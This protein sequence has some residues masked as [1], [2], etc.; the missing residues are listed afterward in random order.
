MDVVCPSMHASNW[1]A[2]TGF[3]NIAVESISNI[4]LNAEEKDI[5]YVV[6]VGDGIAKISGLFTIKAGELIVFSSGLRGLVLNLERDTVGAVILGDDSLVSEND[7]VSPLGQMFQI[8][9]GLDL[10]RHVV[11]ALGLSLEG[12]LSSDSIEPKLVEV[13]APGIIARKSVMTFANRIKSCW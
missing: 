2:V 6:S 10:V 11:D 5:G 12:T 7:L 9:V 1:K 8:N 13:K 4:I 3:F